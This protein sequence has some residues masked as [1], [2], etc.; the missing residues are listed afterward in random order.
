MGD[1]LAKLRFKMR[2]AMWQFVG[3]GALA[4][5]TLAVVAYALTPAKPSVE[6]AAPK[7]QPSATQTAAPRKMVAFIG[8]S[9]TSGTGA[10]N[11]VNRWTTKL[12]VAQDWAETNLGKGG[13]G[14]FN[15]GTTTNFAGS[16]PAAVAAK[17]SIVIVSGGR[18]DVGYGASRFTPAVAEFFPALRAALPNAKI[19]VTSP[20]Y[21]DD[22]GPAAVADLAAAIK[23]NAEKSGAAYVDIGEP[24]LGHPEFVAA[25]G[26]HPNDAGHAAIEA[27]VKQA[28]AAVPGI[29]S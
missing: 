19:I 21:D 14:Y 6:V 8:D 22:A 9:Y 23:A 24:L 5:V 16:I 10:G 1:D 15:S 11:P 18:N 27:A 4:V 17:P 26:I 28:I 2:G 29:K 3:L 12:S 7:V 20:I 13:T 25:D